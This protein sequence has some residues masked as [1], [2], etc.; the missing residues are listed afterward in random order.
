MAIK[1]AFTRE[2]LVEL[3]GWLQEEPKLTL[4]EL[5]QKSVNQGFFPNIGEAP[6]ESTLWRKLQH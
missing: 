4:L 6:D 1:Q 3:A 2:Q 5:L